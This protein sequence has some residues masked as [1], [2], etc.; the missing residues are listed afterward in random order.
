M[1]RWKLSQKLTQTKWLPT[2]IATPK[3][4]YRLGAIADKGSVRANNEDSVLVIE[5]ID[6]FESVSR[7]RI[8]CAVAD[9][10][11]GSEKGE[12]A[13]RITLQ[14][15]ALRASEW[16]S[17]FKET[18]PASVLKAAIESANEAVTANALENP[19][20]QGMASTIVASLID[21]QNLHLTH[22]GDS[23]AYL[24]RQKEILR[25]TKDHSHVQ[26]LIDAGEITGDEAADHPGRNVITRAVG[27]FRDL[28]VDMEQRTISPGE[29]LLLCSD[30]LWDLVQDNQIHELVLKFEDPQ[31]ACK[32]LVSLAN[33]RGGKDNISII[34]VRCELTNPPQS[35]E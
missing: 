5:A 25:L 1:K 13:S 8:L 26:E 24:I 31:T 17:Q 30:G 27:A 22:V 6:L 21:G 9:G 29:A 15:L 3:L 34:I 4:R 14:T 12:V 16:L 10:V 33:E 7:V 2:E 18:E 35:S 20:R 28:E 23:R 11:G 32:E 19:E